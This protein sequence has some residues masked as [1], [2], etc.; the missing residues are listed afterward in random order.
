VVSIYFHASVP[1]PAM[2]T[3]LASGRGGLHIP[4]MYD[5]EKYNKDLQV[6]LLVL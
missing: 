5:N 4:P 2:P 3:G 1:L 6:E